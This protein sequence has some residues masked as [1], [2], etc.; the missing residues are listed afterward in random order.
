M[1]P[2][3]GVNEM[4]W[5][6]TA[7]PNWSTTCALMVIVSSAV[8]SV[9][10]PVATRVVGAP[11]VTVTISVEQT[12]PKQAVT[13]CCPEAYGVK[14]PVEEMLPFDADQTIGAFTGNERWS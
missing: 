12:N 5:L 6:G 1:L 2:F 4:V 7:L 8:I 10:D 11:G 14:T 3:E 13:V 9:A